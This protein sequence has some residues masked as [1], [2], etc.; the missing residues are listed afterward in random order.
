MGIAMNVWPVMHRELRAEARHVFNYW[1]RVLGASVL[2]A[3]FAVMMLDP[4]DHGPELGAKLFGNLNTALF[5]AIWVLAPLLTADCISRERREG[6]LGLLFLTPL[7]SRGIVIGKGLIHTLRA[8]TM[9]FAA[10]PV[11]AVPFLF[12]GVGWREGVM[13]L[14]FDLGS[15]CLAL[16]AGLAASSR[17]ARPD[18][19]LFLSEVLAAILL[20]GLG[21][22]LLLGLLRQVAAPVIPGFTWSEVSLDE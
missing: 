15:G 17:C 14:L 16:A 8:T 20:L 6:T 7:T 9:V 3:V 10:L 4:R 21:A 19:S 2:L 11:L 5:V 12:G 18:P 22:L 13:A 1:L